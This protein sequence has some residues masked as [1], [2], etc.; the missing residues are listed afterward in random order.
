MFIEFDHMKLTLVHDFFHIQSIGMIPLVQF[1]D[2]ISPNVYK[3]CENKSNKTRYS[4]TQDF[5]FYYM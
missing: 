2:V 3:R 4:L 5:S 1:K